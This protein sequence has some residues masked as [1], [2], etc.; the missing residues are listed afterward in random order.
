M[1]FLSLKLKA[2]S[3]L[4]SEIGAPQC[5]PPSVDRLTSSS[6]SLPAELARAKKYPVPSGENVT[7]GSLARR[8]DPPMQTDVPGTATWI[9]VPWYQTLAYTPLDPPLL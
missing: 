1:E 7:H 6:E 5:R 3:S 4:I 8:W 9:Q 2:L